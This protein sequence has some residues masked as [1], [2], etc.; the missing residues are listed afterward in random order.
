MV[1]CLDTYHMLVWYHAYVPILMIYAHLFATLDMVWY[2]M[3]DRCMLG[4]RCDMHDRCMLGFGDEN[5]ML[6]ARCML[7][8]VSLEWQYLMCL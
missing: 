8:C 5:A 3:H 6:I 7:V 4:L 2:E 1:G